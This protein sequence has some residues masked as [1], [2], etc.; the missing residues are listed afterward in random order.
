MGRQE[1]L[2]ITAVL[3]RVYCTLYIDIEL[4][5]DSVYAAS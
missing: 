5:N 4:D 1:V 3:F 2:G